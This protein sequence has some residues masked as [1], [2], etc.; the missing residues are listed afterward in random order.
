MGRECGG[1]IHGARC[2]KTVRTGAV[3]CTSCQ[4]LAA[5]QI[6]ERPGGS[7]LLA[8]FLA[9]NAVP[10][11]AQLLR[12]RLQADAVV[13]AD[14]EAGR[15]RADARHVVYYVRLGL[16]HIKIGTTGRLPRRMHELR[17]VNVDNLLAVEPGGRD[18]EQDRHRQFVK[19]S[20]RRGREDFA[21]APELLDHVHEIR[22]Q[23]G[24]PYAVQGLRAS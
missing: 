13:Q 8:S 12:V 11:A 16:N 9:A 10:L 23:H 22:T 20:W 1:L 3:V 17:V 14:E 5:H 15:R 19:W 2:G 24:E 4:E 21:E 7:D 6:V 18:V